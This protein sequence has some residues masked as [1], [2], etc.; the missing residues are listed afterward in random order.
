M[1]GNKGHNEG[2]E[3]ILNDCAR[4]LGHCVMDRLNSKEMIEVE[5]DKITTS[6]ESIFKKHCWN[7]RAMVQ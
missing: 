2:E 3:S 7:Y 5:K 1:E 4:S 6:I